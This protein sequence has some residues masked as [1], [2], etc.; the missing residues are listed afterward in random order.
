MDYSIGVEVLVDVRQV[1]K[2]DAELVS[3]FMMDTTYPFHGYGVSMSAVSGTHAYE[4]QDMRMRRISLRNSFVENGYM[5]NLLSLSVR[6]YELNGEMGNGGCETTCGDVGVS[7]MEGFGEFTLSSL[8]V[9]QGFSFFLQIGFILILATLDGLDVGL[10]GD[11]IGEMIVMMM[12]ENVF[13]VEKRFNDMCGLFLIRKNECIVSR[14]TKEK[15]NFYVL[16]VY[17]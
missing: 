14:F 1:V 3:R 10:L 12:I 11:V 16:S 15:P 8:D 13:I 5:V 9:L 17:S 2:V 6:T 7:L 4:C